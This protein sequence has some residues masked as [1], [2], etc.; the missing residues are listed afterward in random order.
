MDV[1]DAL[2]I[3]EHGPG[4]DVADV[5]TALVT[6][7]DEVRRLTPAEPGQ[8]V[9]RCGRTFTSSIGLGTHVG[10]L[11]S[12]EHG[13]ARIAPLAVNVVQAQARIA[14]ADALFGEDMPERRA[15]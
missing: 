11:G 10:R 7:A 13:A 5:M 12:Y 2:A 8:Y 4:D 3:A 6:L 1:A 9:C 15:R 14:A